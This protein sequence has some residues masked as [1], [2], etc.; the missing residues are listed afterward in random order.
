[1]NVRSFQSHRT[2]ADLSHFWVICVLSNPVRYK[3]RYELY[4]PFAEMCE[5]AGVNLIT[6]EQAFGQRPFMVTKPHNRR[7]LQLRGHDELWLKERMVNLGIHHA[8]A[9]APGQ[10][11]KVAWIDADS[12][13]KFRK[14]AQCSAA[15]YGFKRDREEIAQEVLLQMCRSPNRGATVDQL[16]I[17]VIRERYGRPRTPGFDRKHALALAVQT[18]E[19]SQPIERTAI[20][21][22]GISLDD[23]L[24]FERMVERLGATDE[25]A[26]ALLRWRHDFTEKEIGY[27]FGVSESRICQ[28]LTAI[29]ERLR[30][31]VRQEERSQEEREASHGS[32]PDEKADQVS[33]QDF[34]FTLD[35]FF[36]DSAL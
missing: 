4:H 12:A 15:R 33:E 29:Q 23:R 35:G 3:R 18:G 25:R 14:R 8:M 34:S 21:G 2:P 27:L 10:V 13:I 9:I 32:E 1:M 17:D 6:V 28:R 16:V 26:F 24:D 30:G 11:D 7:H 22:N 5:T 36:T 20:A 19:G 31:I